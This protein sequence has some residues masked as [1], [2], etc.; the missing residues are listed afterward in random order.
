MAESYNILNKNYFNALKIVCA[1][2]QRKGIEYAVVGGAAAQIL[3]AD[4]VGWK[5]SSLDGRLRKTRD[6]DLSLKVDSDFNP[7]SFFNSL[8]AEENRPGYAVIKDVKINYITEA[9]QFK[10]LES[11]FTSFIE[12]ALEIQH[13]K[14]KDIMFRTEKPEDLII[15]KL[16]RKSKA[17]AKDSFDLISLLKAYDA[18]NKKIDGEEIRSMLKQLGKEELFSEYLEMKYSV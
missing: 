11:F 8:C 9:A 5:S 18:A 15:T 12:G 4:A 16:T 17:K 3:I 14:S 10:G 2:L 1:E 7:I 6:I 13:P